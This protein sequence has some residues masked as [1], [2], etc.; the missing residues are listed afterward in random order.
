MKKTYKNHI[1]KKNFGQHFLRNR[2]IIKKIIKSINPNKKENFLEIGPGMGEIT[3]PMI[4]IVKNISAI[5]VDK[6]IFHILKKNPKLKN[7]SLILQDARKFDF[8]KIEN[9]HPGLLRIFGNLPYNIS[10]NLLFKSIKYIEYIQ[11]MHFTLQKEVAE[12][13]ISNPGSK[14]Y[15]RISVIMQTFYKITPIFSILAKEF[16]PIPKV[17][18]MFLK[19]IPYKKNYISSKNKKKLFFITKLAFLN[20]RKKLS[21]SLKSI[22]KPIDFKKNNIDSSLR[23]EDLDIYKYYKLTKIIK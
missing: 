10:K 9:K 4:K 8:S 1:V 14:K 3:V 11:D 20:R 17:N 21:N 16:Y 22:L 7:L 12:K 6:S 19:F 15:G 18:S 13:I 2:K 5:E 23:A